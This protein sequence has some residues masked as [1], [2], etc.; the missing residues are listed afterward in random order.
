MDAEPVD[1]SIAIAQHVAEGLQRPGLGQMLTRSTK[2]VGLLDSGEDLP[3]LLAQ[4]RR[5]MGAL[6]TLDPV[7]LTGSRPSLSRSADT[8]RKRSRNSP[9]E[10][11]MTRST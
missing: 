3:L 8:S 10:A 7:T 11:R 2:L 5:N 6:L 9:P 1:F 4:T